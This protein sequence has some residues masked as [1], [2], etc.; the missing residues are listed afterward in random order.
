MVKLTTRFVVVVTLEALISRFRLADQRVAIGS[1]V[2]T[3]LSLKVDTVVAARF[4][5]FMP[6]CLACTIYRQDKDLAVMG[7]WT[8]LSPMYR[9]MLHV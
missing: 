2:K 5:Q 4:R 1:P 6:C 8:V 3:E 7:W 9:D